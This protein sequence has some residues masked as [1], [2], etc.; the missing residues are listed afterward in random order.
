[1]II[2]YGT[3]DILAQ[4]LAAFSNRE[5]TPSCEIIVVDN[6]SIPTADR[7][8]S[9]LFPHAQYIFNKE[10]TGFGF[11][12]NQGA[13]ASSGQH[14]L[15]LNGDCFLDPGQL[16]EIFFLVRGL[17]QAGAA[18]FRQVTSDG[19]P[20]LT[21]GEFPTVGSELRRRRFQQALDEQGASWAVDELN[22]LGYP[23]CRVD[24]VSGSC[25]WMPKWVFEKVGGFDEHFFMYFEDIDICRRIQTQLGL[26]IYYCPVPEI[27]HLHG[28]SAA[29]NLRTARVAYRDSQIYF[30]RKH[31]GLMAAGITRLYLLSRSALGW[32]SSWVNGN[33]SRREIT[34]AIFW[35]LLRR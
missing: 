13:N 12:A 4:T 29:G 18:G 17:Q 8:L 35:H 25:L 15:F 2:H 23:P 5:D 10:N 16:R 3:P 27:L 9:D 7:L 6:N 19:R 14:L 26:D 22:N 24:W 21:F 1:V 33:K 32:L 28:A 11:A 30:A 31:A 34:G 20:Q